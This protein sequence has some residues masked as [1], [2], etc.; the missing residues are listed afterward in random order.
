MAQ[1]SGGRQPVLRA[2]RP[3]GGHRR[4]PGGR[5]GARHGGGGAHLPG[6]Q[7]GH[8]H[9]RQDTVTRCVRHAGQQGT[10]EPEVQFLSVSIF[11]VIYSFMKKSLTLLSQIA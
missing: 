2:G 11:D 6:E 3:R 10:A 5:R 1:A 9:H 4:G 7:G 8:R